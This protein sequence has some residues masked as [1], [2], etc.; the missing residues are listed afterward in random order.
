VDDDGGGVLPPPVAVFC[1]VAADLEDM[2]EVEK[3]DAIP[4][5]N[6][7]DDVEVEEGEGDGLF[8]DDEEP[9]I[10]LKKLDVLL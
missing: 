4:L 5:K 8:D 2:V 1:E 3:E 9:V 7:D 10:L 6:F